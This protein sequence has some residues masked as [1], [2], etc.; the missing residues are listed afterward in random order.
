MYLEVSRT[1]EI[2]TCLE[3]SRYVGVYRQSK[4]FGGRVSTHRGIQ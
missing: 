2:C 4:V 1:V 3:L